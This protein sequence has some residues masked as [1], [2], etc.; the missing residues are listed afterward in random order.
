MLVFPITKNLMNS[1]RRKILGRLGLVNVVDIRLVF[2]CKIC[3]Y[4]IKCLTRMPWE[5]SSI[6]QVQLEF[7]GYFAG[8]LGEVMTPLLAPA[9][10][11]IDRYPPQPTRNV[12]RNPRLPIEPSVTKRT[13]RRCSRLVRKSK[14]VRLPVGA[15]EVNWP[16]RDCCVS[17][18]SSFGRSPSYTW[19]LKSIQYSRNFCKMEITVFPFLFFWLRYKGENM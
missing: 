17:R 3:H 2:T 14:R 10:V 7:G 15:L 4:A 9:A 12:A 19:L 1:Y 11:P 5:G 6:S 13:N 8:N 16:Q 18:L